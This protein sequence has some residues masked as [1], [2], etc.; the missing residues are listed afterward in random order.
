MHLEKSLTTAAVTVA[1]LGTLFVAAGPA[2]AG[3]IIVV[4]SPTHDNSCANHKTHTQPR[5]NTSAGS[6]PVNG[7]LA[8][9]PLTTA[10]NHCGGADLPFEDVDQN[11]AAGVG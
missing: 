10:L 5:G 2:A 1:T 11:N 7:L 8:Q 9:L 4:A 6:G 3:G